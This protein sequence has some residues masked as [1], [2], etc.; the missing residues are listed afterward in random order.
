MNYQKKLLL[1]AVMVLLTLG[2]NG[3]PGMG[4]DMIGDTFP[5]TNTIDLYEE[6]PTV[7]YNSQRNYYLVVWT[8]DR[9][10]NDDIQAQKLA[11]NGSPIG[12]PFYISAGKD[13]DRWK[14]DIAYNSM[15]DQ[16]LVVWEDFDNASL[17]TGNS[18]RARVVTGTGEV[19]GKSDIIIRA[20]S[21]L[22]TPS[23]PAV[24]YASVTNRYLVVWHEVSHVGTP[25]HRIFGQFIN[26]Q[27]GL[28]GGVKEIGKSTQLMSPPDVA[29]S[30]RDNRFM[31]AWQQFNPTTKNYDVKGQ[32][33]SGDGDLWGPLGTYMDSGS[34]CE[35]PVVAAMP[36]DASDKT[37]IIAWIHHVPGMNGY[38]IVYVNQAGDQRGWSQALSS[39]GTRRHISIAA[40]LN[41]QTFFIGY[42]YDTG[43]MDKSVWLFQ[44]SAET[45]WLSDFQIPGP[46]ND[47]P[48]IAA[49]PTGD[50]LVVWQGQPLSATTTDIYGQI[51]GIRTYLPMIKK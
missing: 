12:G 17:V 51:L 20:K 11:A 44:V 47:F 46:A 23:D 48:V 19:Q 50:Y 6:Q 28:I 29:Y 34:A 49:G 45:F 31:V 30:A 15:N 14:P 25:T 10:G 36:N 32:R 1:L 16:Y 41:S 4:I 8:N 38:G 24:A 35:G 43:I 27:G 18:I 7:A 40:N 37:Y 13:H 21:S 2:I 39:T 33:V 3:G 5:I 9:P 22:D 26:P 42:Q